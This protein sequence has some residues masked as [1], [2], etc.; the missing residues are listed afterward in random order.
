[1]GGKFIGGQP[2]SLSSSVAGMCQFKMNVFEV[3][4]LAIKSLSRTCITIKKSRCQALI[5]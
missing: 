2:D 3:D 1:M 5:L 4:A